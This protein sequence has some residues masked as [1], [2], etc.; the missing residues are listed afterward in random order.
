M[1][2]GT[3]ED[4]KH[5]PSWGTSNSLALLAHTCEEK[6]ARDQVREKGRSHIVDQVVL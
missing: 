2:K 6:K 3:G 4:E 5:Q 1:R